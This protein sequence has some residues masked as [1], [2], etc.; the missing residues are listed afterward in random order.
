MKIVIWWKVITFVGEGWVCWTGDF[1]R[2]GEWANFL[3]VEE[4]TQFPPSRENP[5]Q[6]NSIQ[7]GMKAIYFIFTCVWLVKKCLPVNSYYLRMFVLKQICSA[8]IHDCCLITLIISGNLNRYVFFLM[9]L[10]LSSNRNSQCVEWHCFNI[11]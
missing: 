11:F 10:Q 5:A 8:S 6:C 7:L 1:S 2:W 4:T 3:I 9:V